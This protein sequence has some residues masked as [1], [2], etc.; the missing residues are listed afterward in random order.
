MLSQ[1]H[2][3]TVR[4]TI[5]LLVSANTLITEHFYNRLFTHHPELQNIF[6]MSHQSTG[7][8]PTALFNAIAAYATHIDNLEVLTSA[9]MRIA[10]K[11]TS[12]NIQPSQYDVVGHHLIETLRELV[13]GAFTPE[14]EEAW[15]AAYQQLANIFIKIEGDLYKQ[16]ANE[17]GGWE[18]FRAF[19]VI[20]KTPESERVTSFVL[21]PV[22]GKKVIDYKAGQY[23]G[24]KIKPKDNEFEEIRQY[25]LSTTANQET[26]R[27]SV[28]R[29]STGQIAGIMSNY[30]HDQVNVSDTIEAMPPAGDFCFEDKQQP[31]VLISG[32]V[33]LTPMQAVL[34]TLAK[35]QYAQPVHYLH[36]CPKASHHS[37]KEHVNNLKSSLDLNIQTW[38]EQL[39]DDQEG[40]FEGQMVLEPIKDSLPLETGDYYLCGPIG[41]MMNVKQQLLSLGVSGERIHYEVFGPHQDV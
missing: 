5:P 34:D 20:S 33:G 30:L 31:V 15:T 29:E 7:R 3:D 8:Q 13:P 38:Y 25:S 12:F 41:F 27:I 14:V 6:N 28:K 35:Q 32:G 9:V 40:V 26:Y 37:F 1:Q 22:D 16:N 39:D 23:L 36:A 17:Q 11:H 2:I 19:K 24:I 10:H 18:D 4:S 21:A